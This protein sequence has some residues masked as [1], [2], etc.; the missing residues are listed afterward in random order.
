[1]GY[2][3]LITNLKNHKL[4]IGQTVNPISYRWREHINEA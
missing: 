2:I 1:M 3:Y 4:Y